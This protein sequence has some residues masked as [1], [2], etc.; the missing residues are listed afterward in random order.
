[1]S[2]VEWKLRSDKFSTRK[3]CYRK[4]TARSSVL[5]I[6]SPDDFDNCYLNSLYKIRCECK[7]TKLNM[8]VC[9]NRMT[10]MTSKRRS[11]SFSLVPIDFS[12]TSSYRLSVVTFALGRIPFSHNTSR[13]Y[14][15]TDGGTQ[16]CTSSATV[17]IGLR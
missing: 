16:H 15:Q 13:R 8:Q 1:M 6:A 7:V 10:L 4:E 5:F 3:P 11:R 12:Y 17:S 9:A 2:T 14:R